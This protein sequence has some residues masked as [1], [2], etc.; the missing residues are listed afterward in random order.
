MKSKFKQIIKSDYFEII[1]RAI[2]GAVAG[3]LMPVVN[4]Q[5][6]FDMNNFYCAIVGAVITGGEKAI[7]LYF[8][9][10]LGQSFKKEPTE[11]TLKSDVSQSSQN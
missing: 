4:H 11:T 5:A 10:S 6:T 8:T 9:N 2:M 3:Y 7:T 1:V